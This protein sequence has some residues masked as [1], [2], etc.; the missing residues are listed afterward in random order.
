MAKDL[1]NPFIEQ[2]SDVAGG[3]LY[4]SR[5]WE[6]W[7]RCRKE[8]MEHIREKLQDP[9]GLLINAEENAVKGGIHMPMLAVYLSNIRRKLVEIANEKGMEVKDE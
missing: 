8:V 7:E 5:D 9:I 4:P 3:K 1:V 2:V 6:V